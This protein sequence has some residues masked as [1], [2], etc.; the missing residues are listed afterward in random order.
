MR[1]K[2]NLLI[3]LG[4]STL[5]LIGF[6]IYGL[7]FN[8]FNGPSQQ[9]KVLHGEGFSSVNYRLFKNKLI[10]NKRLF[11]YYAKYTQQMTKIRTGTYSIP[12]K[13]TIVNI[14]HIL[15]KGK[16]INVKVTIP[17]GKNI[18]EIAKILEAKGICNA[19]DFISTSKDTDFLKT[20]NLPYSSVEGYLYPETYQFQSQS[21]PKF[22]ITTM[23]SQFR[24]KI[25]TLNIQNS[26]LKSLHEIITLASVVEK[27]TGASFERPI[28][29]GVFLNR[30][31]RKIRLQSDP[32]TIYG[33]Y[34]TF[35]GNLR[36]KHLRAKTPYNTYKIPGLPFGPISNPGLASIK[37]VLEPKKHDYLYFVSKNDG[38]HTFSRNYK[39][40]LKAV[41][42][43]QKISKNRR[44]K[45]WRDLKR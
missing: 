3:F 28:I 22:L 13:S 43:F 29:A 7:H 36:K 2:K 1:F 14:L 21:K 9:F 8:T 40:H 33:I 11:H 20:L 30:L 42:Y 24:K 35:N 4:L 34:Q 41:D 37:A 10:T 19:K 26:N 18:Y 39:E 31:D 5:S 17:E 32:T 27:E 23:I 44:G 45:S 12:T 16:S 38:T 15:T 6:L 25:K